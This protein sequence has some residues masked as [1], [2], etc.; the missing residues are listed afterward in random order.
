MF[1]SVAILLGVSFLYGNPRENH[2]CK[3]HILR[4]FFIWEPG[5][6]SLDPA[7][8]T[9]VILVTLAVIMM[10]TTLVSWGKEKA[11]IIKELMQIWQCGLWHEKIQLEKGKEEK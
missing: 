1:L 9:G 5:D 10:D 2:E 7:E 3:P 4:D 6:V 8:R 11:L